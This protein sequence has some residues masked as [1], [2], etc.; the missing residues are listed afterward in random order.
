MPTKTETLRVPGPTTGTG[1][2]RAGK[3]GVL[4]IGGL[5]ALAVLALIW[6]LP[7]LWGITTSLKT[8]ADAA[9]SPFKAPA[10]GWN[11]DAYLQVLRQG[12]VP[13]WMFNSLVISVAVTVLTVGISALAAYGFSRTEF[14]GRKW[15][16]ALTVAAIMVP[17]QILIVPLYQQMNAMLL[18]DTWAGIVLPQIVA[19]MMV[20]ILKNFFDTIPRELE[21]AAR[22][23]G[24]GGLR[25]FL[26]IV[27]PLSRPI[28]VAVSI[29][30]F[31]GAWNNFLWPFIVTNNPDLLTLPVGLATIK[32]AYGVQYAQTMAS[33]ILAALPLLVMFMLF[34]RHIVKGFATSGLGGQ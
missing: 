30:V 32:N 4:K 7:I 5:I 29:F 24:A 17:G 9:G 13:L 21:E 27:M 20:F 10:G 14:R 16:F 22:I 19:P 2:S 12:D 25:V 1:A 34:Q 31:I 8:E 33:A 15:L 18:T 3:T 28:L 26:T 6:L 11:F 23:D